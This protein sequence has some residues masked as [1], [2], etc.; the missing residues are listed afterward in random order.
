MFQSQVFECTQKSGAEV[1]SRKGG[2]GWAVGVAINNVI[3]SIALNRHQIL[4][5]SSLVRGLYGINDVC[6]SVPTVVGRGGVERLLEIEL[7]PKELQGLQASAKALK[8]T[9]AK[10]SRT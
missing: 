5:I 4:P 2:A 3:E 1:I 8:D 7:W 9:Y 6:L 10:V